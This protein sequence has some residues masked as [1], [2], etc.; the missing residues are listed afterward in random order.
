MTDIEL[1]HP[2]T[3]PELQSL[4]AELVACLSEADVDDKALLLLIEQRDSFINSY[5][6]RLSEDLKPSFVEKELIA[7]SQLTQ[8][9]HSLYKDSLSK[10]STLARNKKSLKHYG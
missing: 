10:L 4:N 6:T 5:L 9:A 1:D 7:N 3:P 8:L 2:F